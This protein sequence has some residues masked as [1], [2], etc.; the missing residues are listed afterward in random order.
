MESHFQTGS[1]FKRKNKNLLYANNYYDSNDDIKR[2]AYIELHVCCIS[3]Q[4]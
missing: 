3:L 2:V 1:I 4:P